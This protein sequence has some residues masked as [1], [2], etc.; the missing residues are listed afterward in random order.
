MCR[1]IIRTVYREGTKRM[2]EPQG[3]IINIFFRRVLFEKVQCTGDCGLTGRFAAIE[4][5]SRLKGS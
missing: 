5:T 3:L 4:Q 2:I 1:E